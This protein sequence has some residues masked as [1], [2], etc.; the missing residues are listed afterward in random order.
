MSISS[1]CT[2]AIIYV[3]IGFIFLIITALKKFNMVSTIIS[4]FLIL[5]WTW[6]LNFLC[7]KDYK[8]VAWLL[9]IFLSF[10]LLNA[11]QLF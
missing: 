7:I 5:L 4:L 2:P 8:I 3:I 10:G 9:L 6:F 1:K 11:I